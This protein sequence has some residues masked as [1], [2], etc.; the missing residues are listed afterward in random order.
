MKYPWTLEGTVRSTTDHQTPS[1]HTQ[2]LSASEKT[3]VPKEAVRQ[4]PQGRPFGN[5]P[6]TL[7][8]YQVEDKMKTCR[9]NEESEENT[10]KLWI[11]SHLS[12]AL[13]ACTSETYQRE[14]YRNG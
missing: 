10:R 2:T 11:R 8:G 4:I 7:Q 9:K 13:K 12:T 6:H 14:S 3:L 1:R 5:K